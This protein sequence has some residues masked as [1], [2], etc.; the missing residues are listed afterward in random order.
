MVRS[1]KI[2][3]GAFLLALL[4]SAAFGQAV[5]HFPK[6]QGMVSDYAG[7]LSPAAKQRLENLL[8]NFRDRSGGISL[9]IVLVPHSYLG[10][11]PI[12]D[13]ALEL[14]R[15][16]GVGGGPDKAGLLLL[17]AIKGPDERGQY[18]GQTRLEVSRS[19][20]GDIPDGLAGEMIR[21]MR[22]DLRAGRFDQAVTAGAQTIL[23]TLAEKRGISLEGIESRYAYRAPAPQR[24]L[25]ATTIIQVL[26]VVFAV[27]I[28]LILAIR[29]SM[30]SRRKSQ[31]PFTEDHLWLLG[32]S[33][34][35]RF[36]SAGDS[37]RFGS[38]GD[39]GGGDFGGFDSGGDFGGGGASDSW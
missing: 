39:F 31:T 6:P 7:K 11:L 23:A 38:G 37:G 26:I 24:G 27:I 21:R 3:P 4:F 1:R 20:E 13:Y 22:D 15:T 30:K 9:A 8:I 36:S 18:S 32:L 25:D 14:G 28:P 17:V 10:G 12:E 35:D 29:G 33:D 34:F 19:L 2:L 5:P 16:W